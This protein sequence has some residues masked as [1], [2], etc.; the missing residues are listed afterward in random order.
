MRLVAASDLDGGTD[1]LAIDDAIDEVA[2]IGV[3]ALREGC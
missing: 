1:K 2:S 3:Q